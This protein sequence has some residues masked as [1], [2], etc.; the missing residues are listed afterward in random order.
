MATGLAAVC[1]E[2]QA[3]TLVAEAGIEVIEGSGGGD[4][5]KSL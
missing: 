2:L 4:D 1:P 3:L 5:E